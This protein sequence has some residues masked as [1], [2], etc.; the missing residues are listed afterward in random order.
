MKLSDK[1]GDLCLDLLAL[2]TEVDWIDYHSCWPCYRP[3]S[4]RFLTRLEGSDCETVILALFLPWTIVADVLL[5]II[6]D[7]ATYIPTFI[8]LSVSGVDINDAA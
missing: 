7:I 2:K 4:A 5:R 1:P 8:Y 6:Y 3:E